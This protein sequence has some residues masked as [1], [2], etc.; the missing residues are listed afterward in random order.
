M[1]NKTPFLRFFFLGLRGFSVVDYQYSVMTMGIN[2]QNI[3]LFWLKHLHRIF[4]Y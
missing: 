3:S 4:T 2:K 1:E